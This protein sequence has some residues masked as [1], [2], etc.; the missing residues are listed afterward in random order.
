V[1]ALLLAPLVAVAVLGVVN[2]LLTKVVF[3]RAL[4]PATASRT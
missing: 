4:F 2:P 1:L 3:D